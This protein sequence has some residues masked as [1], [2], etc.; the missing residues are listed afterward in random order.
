M[1]TVA[2]VGALMLGSVSSVLAQ[3]PQQ[4]RRMRADDATPAM[5]ARGMRGPR[6][7]GLDTRVGQLMDHRYALGLDDEQM[8]QLEALRRDAHSQLA[9]LR[10][11]MQAL[12]DGIQD[13]TVTASDAR[14]RGQAL[15]ERVQAA[16]A[17]LRVRLE[18]LL[19]PE[20]RVQLRGRALRAG[21]RSGAV[22]R[23][24]MSVGRRGGLR[25]APG[26][27]RR[28]GGQGGPAGQGG[29]P[30]GPRRGGGS[31]NPGFQGSPGGFPPR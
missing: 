22:N 27:R 7:M 20:Q 14:E 26:M 23:P 3:R 28:P 11:E 2:L 13:G 10:E 25:G 1:R 30:M 9:P 4:Q 21:A 31:R 17:P 8:S 19:T 12:R 6:V 16:D 18:N 29:P 24:G 15:R 5:G